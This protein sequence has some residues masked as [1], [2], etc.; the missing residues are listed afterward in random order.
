MRDLA[1]DA[2]TVLALTHEAS[3]EDFDSSIAGAAAPQTCVERRR[4]RA[5][6]KRREAGQ[7]AAE[8][9]PRCQSGSC[10]TGYGAARHRQT[11]VFA[12]IDFLSEPRANAK[13]RSA[14]AG[15]TWASRA[16]AA[17]ARA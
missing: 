14:A 13:A 1:T 12:Q 6:G 11:S 3:T 7:A 5:V 15:A 9:T 17:F 2:A 10:I 4:T 16:R 8:E